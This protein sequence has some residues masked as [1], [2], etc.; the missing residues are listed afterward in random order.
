VLEVLVLAVWV[1]AVWVPAVW[2]W[3]PEVLALVPAALVLAALVL[4][5][6]W[7]GSHCH[8]CRSWSNL[9]CTVRLNLLGSRR[10]CQKF[11]TH[12]SSI[13]DQLMRP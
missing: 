2:E 13:W 11:Q 1:L 7:L 9:C 5:L 8:Y 12:S 6:A 3:E 10:R 4:A